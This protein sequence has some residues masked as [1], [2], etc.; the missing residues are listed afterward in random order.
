MVYSTPGE[1]GGIYIYGGNVFMVNNILYNDSPEEIFFA[2]TGLSSVLVAYSDVEGGE[3]GIVTSSY[4]TVNWQEGNIN[5]DPKLSDPENGDY[6]LQNNSQLIDAGIAYYNWQGTV[7]VDLDA[8]E[9]SGSAPDIGAQESGS[10]GNINQPPVAMASATPDH[11]SSPLT[12]E[13]SSTGSNDP[14]GTIV[15]YNW[16]FGDGASSSEPNPT[17]TFTGVNQYSVTLTVTDDKNASNTKAIIINVQDGTTITGGNV[18]GNWTLANS[19]YRIE[20]DIVV[21]SGQTLT[22]EPGVIVKFTGWYKILVNGKLAAVGT[23]SDSIRFTSVPPGPGEPGWVGI[24][25]VNADN[26]SVLEYCVIENGKAFAADPN[27]RGGAL[28]FLNSSPAIKYSSLKNNQASKYGG[29]IYCDSASPVIEGCEIVNNSAGFGTSAAG[30]AIYCTNNSQ[31]QILRNNI[32]NNSVGASGGYSPGNANGGAIYL[33]QSDAVIDGNIISL[34]T[35]SASGNVPT[36]SRG[37]AISIWNCNPVITGN[38]VYANSASGGNPQGGGLF[39]Y[40]SNPVTV[41]NIFWNNTSEAVFIASSYNPG[42]IVVAYSDVEGGQ[43]GI[44]I[45]DNGIVY[46]QEGN[47]NADPKFTDAENA[48]FSLLSS[49]QCIDAGTAYYAWQ[50]NMV[51]DIA[52]SDYNGN[53]PDMGALESAFTAP[54]NLPPVAAAS[55]SPLS[56]EA[57]LTVQFNSNASYDPDGMITAYL[58]QSG[59]LSSANPNPSYTFNNPGIYNVLLTVTDDDG[60]QGT[61][62]LTIEVSAPTVDALHVGKQTVTREYYRRKYMAVDEVLVLDQN[63]Q[64]VANATVTASYNGPT[65]GIVS[66]VTGSDG[67][68][69]LYSRNTRKANSTWC[70]E[71]TDV[72]KNGYGYNSENNAVTTQCEGSS[73]F[74]SGNLTV[75]SDVNLKTEL[76]ETSVYPNPFSNDITVRFELNGD[77]PV[78]IRIFDITGKTVSLLEN[79]TRMQAGI[80]NLQWFGNDNS[81]KQ[82]PEG[83][84]FLRLNING[85]GETFKLVHT[86]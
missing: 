81:G 19:P 55:A 46:W 57:P 5:K 9:Y 16:D 85:T 2:S 48:D 15:S 68:V 6:S 56:G 3:Q 32:S 1:G 21:P 22:I 50:G 24:D 43:S 74:K 7:L 63:D 4:S 62:A 28:Y 51:V 40:N 38:T 37:G 25:F 42:S 78:N 66:G 36:Y 53:A 69:E 18:S 64:P 72:S 23:E 35:S 45:E 75:K 70:F 14:D 13:F 58:W 65:N 77:Q 79:N 31:P 71:I 39:I 34:N 83:I 8:S 82:L 60:A 20:G 11:G 41:N 29:A 27:D 73:F 80:H 33:N 12:V 44:G 17:H 67:I 76:V 61:D 30:G 84:Y 49:S 47:I 59:T 52:G 26:N 54:S 10:S 86:R